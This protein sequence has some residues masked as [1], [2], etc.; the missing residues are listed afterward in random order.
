MSTVQKNAGTNVSC[1]YCGN[2]PTNH[3]LS[4]FNNTFSVYMLGFM[5]S[6][7][8][9][10]THYSEIVEDHLV[11]ALFSLFTL[12]RV[13]SFTADLVK[14]VS[15]RSRVI[16]EEAV[17]RG[18]TI[19]QAY[20]FGIATEHYRVREGRTWFYF[21]SIPIPPSQSK[22]ETWI[23]SKHSLK[24]FFERAQVRVPR[25]GKA[26]SLAQAERIFNE[27]Q[28]PVIV[29]PEVGSR[30]RHTLTYIMTLD[31]FRE[32][33]AIAQAICKSVIV[34]EHLVGSVYRATYVH[35]EVVGILRGDPP[36]ITG[37]GSTTIEKLI[38]RKN[39]TKHA[40]QK[41]F[42]PTAASLEF[43]NRQGYAL[44]AILEAGKTIDLTEKIGLSYGGYAVEDFP[45]AHPKLLAALT[46]AG[47]T[48]GVPL[49]G[50]DFIS[51]NIEADPD[52]VRWGIIE[53]NTLPF[54][55]LHHFPVEG[56]PINVAAKVWDMWEVHTRSGN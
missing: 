25:G 9:S 5:K 23:D 7:N 26:T 45:R 22:A 34:E 40:R 43:L 16:W 18:M 2:N 39:A 50:F 6:Q 38:E 14:P 19:E 51:E 35:G 42:K 10:W 28:K 30:G 31:E 54:I 1:S 32:A 29:K 8:T 20:F 56:E 3:A 47:D 41:D 44:D 52:Q 11:R 17:R 15:D 37:D 24:R 49:V 21:M 55:D 33:F 46:H 13:A 53:A 48:L 12:L 27:V 4:Y 36:R